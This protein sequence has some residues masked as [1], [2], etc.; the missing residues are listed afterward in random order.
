MHMYTSFNEAISA[1]CLTV[2]GSFIGLSLFNVKSV[3]R[4]CRTAQ[5]TRAKHERFVYFKKK[6]EKKKGFITLYANDTN[7]FRELLN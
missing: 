7:E 3:L 1:K 4:V 2:D 5:R 6:R